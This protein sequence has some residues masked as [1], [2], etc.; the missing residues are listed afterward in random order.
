MRII[1]LD[2]HATSDAVTAVV[3]DVDDDPP[4]DWKPVHFS[5]PMNLIRKLEALA[6][7]SI[8]E[9]EIISDG[10]PTHLGGLNY[11]P[12]TNDLNAV[13]F[14]ESIR[15]VVGFSAESVIYL[16]GCNT[17]CRF[18]GFALD[19]F[20]GQNLANAAGCVVRGAKGYITGFHARG[21]ERCVRDLDGV[22]ASTYPG[23][24]NVEG[25]RCWRT[26]EP[27]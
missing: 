11:Q 18:S 7:N 27:K 19:Q 16:S 2:T 22:N 25:D 9:L 20:I 8:E 21:N 1:A 3:N 10:S 6:A 23:S 13:D 24:R 15:A 26:F 14:G 12:S 17:G 4:P 5:S